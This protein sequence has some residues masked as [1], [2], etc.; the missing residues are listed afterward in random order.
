MELG[1]I[2]QINIDVEMQ[3]SYLDYAMSVI[4][5]RALPDARDGLKPVHRRILYAMHDLGL[6]P[7]KPYKKSARIVG[8]VLGKYHPHGD[9]AV[10]EAMVRMAQDFSLR[11]PLVDGQG[12]FG[13]VD[14][15]NAAA[16][17]Y[18]EAR[19]S[20]IA[21]E[22]L[23]DI[24]KDTV[25]WTDNFDGTLK[26][27]TV[28]PAMLPNLLVNGA[29]GIAVGMA[30]NI[31]PH[32]LGEV[33]DALCFLIDNFK[34]H[35]D[36]TVDDLMQFIPG[37]DF[38]TGGVIYRYAQEGTGDAAEQ[39]DV[40]AHAYAGGKGHIVMQAKA[41]IED[42]SRNR[43]R[44]VVTE[45]PYMTN[46]TNLLERIAELVRDGRLEGITDLRDESDRTGMRV[47]IEMTRTVEPRQILADLFKLT[48]LQN[49]FGVSLLALVDG[50]PKLLSLKRMLLHYIEHRQEVIVRRAKHDLA[51]AKLRAHIL[52]GLLRALD[53]LDEVIAT[54]RKSRNA[55]TAKQNLIEEFKFTD[56]QAQAILDMQLR[57]LAALERRKLQDEYRETIALI[58]ELE[59]LLDSPQR[60]LALIKENLLDLKARYG[61]ARRTQIAD[62]VKGTLTTMD[63]LP[64]EDVWI[65]LSTDGMI[66]QAT[67]WYR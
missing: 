58:R 66:A 48:P 1:I 38:P 18:T 15:D 31:P 51:K 37:P 28:L 17:R 22:M 41:H 30:T 25:D 55:D 35:D 64:D 57:R 10:Y 47:C 33:V 59:A 54:I 45:L 3:A 2:R 60:V 52:E 62:R 13:S 19:L 67:P 26:E 46:K 61:D 12:N 49:T 56:I 8:E 63:V 44:I 43:A 20:K 4:V 16:M 39:V 6:D 21:V 24:D 23:A 27:P 7:A 29:S 9:A 40:I 11:Y 42:M 32:N 36:V 5:A 34:R 53:V 14:G 50:E 65:S